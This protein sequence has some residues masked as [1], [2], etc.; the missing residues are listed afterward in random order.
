MI[1]GDWS[2]RATYALA[3]VAQ[4]ME[5][6]QERQELDRTSLGVVKPK[7]IQKL[8]IETAEPTWSREFLESASA[9]RLWDDKPVTKT[10]PR[11]V[12]FKFSFQFKCNDARCTGHRMMDE[13][14]EVGALY[15]RLVDN[16]ATPAKAADAVRTK[17]QAQ[18]WQPGHNTH[19][20]VGT[21]S[22]HPKSW[23]II[24]VFPGFG[25]LFPDG[26]TLR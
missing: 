17:F 2:V 22:G 25:E 6:L 23:V 4:S 24:G 21:V 18:M 13:D 20:F 3:N 26:V 7:V 9:R 1:E 11:K 8:V 15:W 19:F 10:P 16:G 14:W 12:L 5:E